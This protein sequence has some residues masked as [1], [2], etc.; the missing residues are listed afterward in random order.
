[1]VRALAQVCVTIM[2]SLAQLNIGA[3][4]ALCA[5]AAVFWLVPGAHPAEPNASVVPPG[6]DC[7]P[8]ARLAWG[9]FGIAAKRIEWYNIPF[10][11]LTRQ[12]VQLTPYVFEVTLNLQGRV[13]A[14]T[15]LSEPQPRLRAI[16]CT[17]IS[18]WRFKTLRPGGIPA[19]Y[20]TRVLFYVR[21]RRGLPAIEV[22][23]LT[24]QSLR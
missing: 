12:D 7:G 14:C 10:A 22:P 18:R 23:G 21:K 13:C 17:S 8:S 9:P 19:C 4:R 20:Q 6:C 16:L 15:P 1:M 3:T 5:L 2:Y 24:D 11:Q